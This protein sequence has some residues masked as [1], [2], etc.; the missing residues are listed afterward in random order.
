[1][2]S[3]K[4]NEAVEY[5]WSTTLDPVYRNPTVPKKLVNQTKHAEKIIRTFNRIGD[6]VT[7]MSR[8]KRGD[9]SASG[10][11]EMRD[12]GVPTFE[13]IHYEFL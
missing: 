7:Y 13:S 6:L 8:F 3:T 9:A 2:A 12:A 1:M 11:K 10:T 4:L 5:I